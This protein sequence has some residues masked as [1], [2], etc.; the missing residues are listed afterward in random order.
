MI[1]KRCVR[2]IS[3]RSAESREVLPEPREPVMRIED[4]PSTKNERIAA[5]LQLINPALTRLG[6]VK[7]LE[8]CFRKAKATPENVRGSI[9][10]ETRTP[11]RAI[12][13]LRIG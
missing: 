11:K 2:G 8:R 12:L 1:K 7:G 10:P 3:R 6:S 4:W 9:M 5:P 13:A